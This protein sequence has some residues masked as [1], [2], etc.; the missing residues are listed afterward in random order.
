MEIEEFIQYK[1]KV[2]YELA[3]HVQEVF[4]KF[5]EDTGVLPLGVEFIFNT[6]HEYNKPVYAYATHAN[7]QVDI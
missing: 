7:I 3:Q 5:G 2:E 6:M 1:K 4:K